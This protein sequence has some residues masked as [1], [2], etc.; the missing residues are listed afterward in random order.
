[1]KCLPETAF[2]TASSAATHTAQVCL[3]GAPPTHQTS[4]DMQF[5]VYVSWAIKH[6]PNMVAS[7]FLA[8]PIVFLLCKKDVCFNF[9]Y[10]KPKTWVELVLQYFASQEIHIAKTLKQHF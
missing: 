5:P 4:S 3:H 6:R 10:L 1:M 8:G 7:A 9:V 2:L